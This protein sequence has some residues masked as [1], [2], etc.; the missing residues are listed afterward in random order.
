M[1][2]EELEAARHI[3]GS[4]LEQPTEGLDEDHLFS[5]VQQGIVAERAMRATA[6]GG[7]CTLK[8]NAL[9]ALGG[10]RLR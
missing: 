2:T 3:V 10:A 9:L 1:T 5:L 4:L 6:S 8:L 7:G